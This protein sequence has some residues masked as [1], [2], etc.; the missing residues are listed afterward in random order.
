MRRLIVLLACAVA[1]SAFAQVSRPPMGGTSGRP[2]GPPSGSIEGFLGVWTLV[3]QGPIDAG[4][5][6]RGTLT[7]TVNDFGEL[8]GVWKMKGPPATLSGPVGYDRNVWAGRFEQSD[9]ADFP[10]RGH[11]R[12]ETRDEHLLNGSYQPEGTAIPYTWTATR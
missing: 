11:F 2:L 5:P 10:M 3:W 12:L 1:S 6:C 8:R 9:E 4:C 7:I